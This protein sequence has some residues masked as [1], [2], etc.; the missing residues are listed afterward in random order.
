MKARLG[1]DS[2]HLK[3]AAWI[4]VPFTIINLLASFSIRSLL[5]PLAGPYCIFGGETWRNGWTDGSLQ[6]AIT[7]S[8]L[9]GGAVLFQIFAKRLRLSPEGKYIIWTVGLIGWV[10]S[11]YLSILGTIG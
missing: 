9:M 2:C 8:I 6:V 5:M 7:A 3:I 10:L 11:G 4:V 1:F